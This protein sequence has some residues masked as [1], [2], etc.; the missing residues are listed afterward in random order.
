MSE[1][2]DKCR[3]FIEKSN[4]N[5][6]QIAKKS[7]LDRTM[8][9]KM[10]KGTKVPSPTFFEKFCDFLVINKAE[11]EELEKLFKIERMGR[12]V[13][14]CRCEIENLL[15]DFRNLKASS[16]KNLSENWLDA[17]PQFERTLS[18]KQSVNIN[19]EV[20]MIDAIR[21][22]VRE[23]CASQENPHIYM[24]VFDETPFALNQILKCIE[25]SDKQIIC[26][27]FVKF[28]RSTPSHNV[29]V[30]NI[31][32]LRMIFPFAISFPYEY[33]VYCSYIDGNRQDGNFSCWA[34]NIVTQSKVLLISEKGDEGLLI[35]DEAIASGYIERM[36]SMMNSCEKLFSAHDKTVNAELVNSYEMQ[37]QG[38]KIALVEPYYI[39]FH[40]AQKELP[41]SMICLKEPGLFEAFKDYFANQMDEQ[42]NYCVKESY[43]SF[44][45]WEE[46]LLELYRELEKGHCDKS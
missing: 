7:G 4:T 39:L 1:F 20:D 23:E 45:Q 40:F 12:D 6:Y 11:K 38:L 17:E 3:A 19:S 36:E 43:E 44:N 32:S 28:G 8:L 14:A 24:D 46:V 16:K 31:R 2:S 13:Y 18:E 33:D 27:Q 9:Q 35:D 25:M 21:F 41:S 5:V 30:E 15:S 26:T 22:I 34:H 29:T 37:E 42:E 10:V